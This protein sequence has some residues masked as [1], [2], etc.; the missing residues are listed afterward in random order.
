MILKSREHEEG[1]KTSRVMGCFSFSLS[2]NEIWI[3]PI[4]GLKFDDWPIWW[5][6][7]YWQKP[8]SEEREA[9]IVEEQVDNKNFFLF[10]GY[11]GKQFQKEWPRKLTLLTEPD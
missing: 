8:L 4:W 5:V 7:C 11:D 10:E 6:L 1:L 3:C 9:W 2:Q